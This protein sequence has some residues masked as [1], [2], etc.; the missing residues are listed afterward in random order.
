MQ[1][2]DKETGEK[3]HAMLASEMD[4]KPLPDWLIK[5]SFT[6]LNYDYRGFHSLSFSQR[7]ECFCA[8]TTE[9]VICDSNGRISCVDPKEFEKYYTKANA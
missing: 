8:D 5:N 2:Q 9:Y 7:G 6:S 4:G 3:V 1:Y